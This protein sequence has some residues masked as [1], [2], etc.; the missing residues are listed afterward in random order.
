M[1]QLR[2]GRHKNIRYPI[3][4]Q[5]LRNMNQIEQIARNYNN[6]VTDDNVEVYL[7]AISYR[8]TVYNEVPPDDEEDENEGE[9]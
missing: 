4:R 6:Y 3:K 9:N 1:T 5:Y 2:E 8:I 7:R